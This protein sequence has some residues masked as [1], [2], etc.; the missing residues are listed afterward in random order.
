MGQKADTLKTLFSWE[1]SSRKKARTGKSIDQSSKE[2]DYINDYKTKHALLILI[3]KRVFLLTSKINNN[4]CFII[5]A[6]SRV[7]LKLVS[8]KWTRRVTIMWAWMRANTS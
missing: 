6:D 2:Y 4:D 5:V 3:L 8:S 7:I 1:N